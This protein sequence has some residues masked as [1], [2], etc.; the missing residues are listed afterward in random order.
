[1]PGRLAVTFGKHRKQMNIIFTFIL[2]LC[3]FVSCNNKG[4]EKQTAIKQDTGI[5]KIVTHKTP[6]VLFLYHLKI[7]DSAAKL[8]LNDTIRCCSVS[9][10]FMEENTE[11]ET[12]TEGSYVGPLSFLKKDLRKWHEWFDKEYAQK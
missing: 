3:L 7:L 8:A 6:E 5:K 10:E 11:I 1:M 2:L 9:I 4:D 12:D